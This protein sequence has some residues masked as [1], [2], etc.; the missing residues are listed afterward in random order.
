MGW[1]ILIVLIT[2]VF[3]MVYSRNK[4]PKVKNISQVKEIEK[5]TKQFFYGEK[6]QAKKFEKDEII[7]D[8]SVI[9]KENDKTE[10]ILKDMRLKYIEQQLDKKEPPFYKKNN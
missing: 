9:D 6:T 8:Q 5:Y 3:M 4:K 10:K 2:V 1:L 7:L